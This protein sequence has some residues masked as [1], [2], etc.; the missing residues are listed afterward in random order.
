MGDG[1][2]VSTPYE[3]DGVT[4]RSI[5]SERDVTEDTLG[6]CD[7]DCM[8]GTATGAIHG[9]SRGGNVGSHGAVRGHAFC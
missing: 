4:D 3:H 6:R 2:L 9:R 8:G 1:V 5:G 7:N